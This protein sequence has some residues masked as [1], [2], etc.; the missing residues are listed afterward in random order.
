VGDDLTKNYVLPLERALLDASHAPEGGFP[1]P[2]PELELIVLVLRLILKHGPWDAVLLRR[3]VVP[4]SAREELVYLQARVDRE[5]LGTYLEQCLPAVDRGLFDDCE[6]ALGPGAGAR[7]RISAARRLLPRLAADARRSRGADA[8]VAFWRQGSGYLRRAPRKKRLSRGGAVI[9]VVGADGAGKSTVVEGLHRWLAKDFQVT[10]AHLGKPPR[11]ITSTLV[12]TGARVAAGV[13]KLRGRGADADAVVTRGWRRSAVVAV[14]T[15]RDRFAAH[16][17]ARRIAGNG[18]LVVTD[19][20]PVRQVTLMDGPRIGPIVRPPEGSRLAERLSSLERRYYDRLRPPDVL[21]VLRLD[22]E[23]AVARRS[24]EDPDFVRTRNREVWEAD[25]AE[26]AAHV[27]D[28]SR[29]ADEVLDKVKAIV[30]AA[31]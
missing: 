25:W 20:Y 4:A 14:A 10:R 24:D 11:S 26:T 15:A 7:A 19:R 3:G 30:W 5:L 27:V 22:P 29:P 1:I 18:G 16:A 31:L 9:A 2:P 12:G 6:R 28:A 21:V 8:A 17:R 13:S 23:I